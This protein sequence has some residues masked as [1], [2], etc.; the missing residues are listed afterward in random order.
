MCA[1]MLDAAVCAYSVMH[2][3]HQLST[4]GLHTLP[5]AVETPKKS[6]MQLTADKYTRNEHN[7]VTAF[8]LLDEL[9]IVSMAY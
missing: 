5:V 1:P 4:A 3:A 9:Y 6:S 2:T 7:V 8:G